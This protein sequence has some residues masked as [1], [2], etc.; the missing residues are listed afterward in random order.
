MSLS[1]IHRTVGSFLGKQLFTTLN[2][3]IPDGEKE[4]AADA[5][6]QLRTTGK[7]RVKKGMLNVS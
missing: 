1:W 6:E 3:I 7:R 4:A 2:N 5:T